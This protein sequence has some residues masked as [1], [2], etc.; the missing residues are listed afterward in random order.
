MKA[1]IV[2]L[3]GD[4][5]GPEV[6]H[7]ARIVLELVAKRFGHQLSF[8]EHLI[9][10]IAINR[11]GDPLPDETLA[12][13]KRVDAGAARC[14]RRTE[15]G[16]SEGARAPRAGPAPHSQGARRSTRTCGPVR[17]HP[18]LAGVSPL[19]PEQRRGRRRALR[20]RA[21]GRRSTSASRSARENGRQAVACRRHARVP[22]GRDPP[23]RAASRSSW[24][25]RGA[26]G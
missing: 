25:A 19:K 7:E 22:R 5:I 9:G 17:V 1:T 10:G 26:S 20:A 3:P 23:R 13:C 15:V 24:R 4:G 11:T 16:Q 2:L 8:S 6:V 18:A 12:A 21:D 14:G